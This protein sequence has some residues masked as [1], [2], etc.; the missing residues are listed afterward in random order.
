MPFSQEPF[1]A[2]STEPELASATTKFP[3]ALEDVTLLNVQSS[4]SV[5]ALVKSY[6]K[7]EPSAWST[8]AIFL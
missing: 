4:A 2:V 3:S 7:P 8:G 6:L 5:S 1:V